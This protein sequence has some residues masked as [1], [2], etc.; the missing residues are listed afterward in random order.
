MHRAWD[1]TV[2]TRRH[3]N[4]D[5]NNC[6]HQNLFIFECTEDFLNDSSTDFYRLILLLWSLISVKASSFVVCF[7]RWNGR[8][9]CHKC[10]QF[11]WRVVSKT[12]N[13][14]IEN[15]VIKSLSHWHNHRNC[16]EKWREIDRECLHSRSKSPFYVRLLTKWGSFQILSMAILPQFH[17]YIFIA[18]AV[19]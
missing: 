10:I 18:D 13:G 12:D 4:D 6:A 9:A 5:Y 7:E 17:C 19:I 1:C 11:Q 14:Y 2:R 8:H 16:R 3:P 15:E